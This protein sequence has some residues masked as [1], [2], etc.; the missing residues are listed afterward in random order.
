VSRRVV[1]QLFAGLL[2]LPG[3]GCLT[4]LHGPGG[5]AAPDGSRDSAGG[6]PELAPAASAKVNL[7]VAEA[8]EKNGHPADAAFHYEKARQGDPS[9]HVAARLARLYDRLGNE[10]RA[11]AEYQRALKEDSRDADVYA[12]L[13]YFYYARGQWAEAEENLHHALSINPKHQRAWVNLG[14]TLGEQGQYDKSL[15]AFRKAVSEA[16]AHSNLAFVLTTQ[17]K[18]EEAKEEYRRALELDPNLAI[19]RRALGKLEHPAAAADGAAPAEAPE[20]RPARQHGDSLVL[21]AAQNSPAGPQVDASPIM[22]DGPT[23]QETKDPE[24]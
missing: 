1:C 18:R 17:G 10:S 9:L 16:E 4:P 2:L 15:D 3:A 21:P 24:Q 23:P 6:K 7:K 5:L 20:F 13:G 14:L 12:S 22:V 8:M 19:A 11:L